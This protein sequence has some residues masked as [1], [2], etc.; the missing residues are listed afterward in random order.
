MPLTVNPFVDDPDKAEVFELGYL[1]GLQDPDADPFL[2]LSPE[3]L[4]VFN[5]GVKAGRADI[6][7]PVAGEGSSN[8]VKRS[9]LG[10]DEGIT[11]LIEHVAIEAVFEIPAH[12]FKL[13]ELGLVGVVISVLGIPGDVELRPLEPDFSEEYSGPDTDAN[14]SYV[15]ACSRS[16]HPLVMAGVTPEGYWAGTGTNDFNEALKE[17]LRHGHPE[18][19]V[20]RCSTTD[21]TCGPVWAAT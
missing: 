7:Q 20:A 16:D 8:W 1:A 5:Q 13:V 3:L 14:V 9:E 10:A 6:P 19:L 18:T 12:M 21:N 2:P 15:A 11:D 17:A 4:D